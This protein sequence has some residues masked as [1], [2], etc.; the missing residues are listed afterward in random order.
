MGS[1]TITVTASSGG[2]THTTQLILTVGLVGDT[3]NDCSVNIIDLA[4]VGAAFGST[5]ADSN[6]DPNADL[7]DDITI[8]II[9]LTIIGSRFGRT[10]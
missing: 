1:F 5:P 4:A 3:N 8:N 9:D 6:W 10:C 2:L 7:N